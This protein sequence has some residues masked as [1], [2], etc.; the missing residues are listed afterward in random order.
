[1][2]TAK[3]TYNIL[4]KKQPVNKHNNNTIM[5]FQRCTDK[6]MGD[7]LKRKQLEELRKQGKVA[8]SADPDDVVDEV[9]FGAPDV[10]GATQ[11]QVCGAAVAGAVTGALMGGAVGAMAGAA[12][13]AFAAAK[14]ECEI[15]EVA[16]SAGDSVCNRSEGLLAN[17]AVKGT[18]ERA[19]RTAQKASFRASQTK[20]QLLFRGS[21][22]AVKALQIKEGA[23]KVKQRAGMVIGGRM[24]KN[25][26]NGEDEETEFHECLDDNVLDVEDGEFEDAREELKELPRSV[27]EVIGLLD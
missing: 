24:R 3:H 23:S 7:I 26:S 2:Q 25:I 20:Q 27:K 12:G 14:R 4:H 15:G 18:V 5:G 1:L 8:P 16:R 10:V 11:R 9:V 6:S 13:A 17:P 21:Q 19:S 22:C